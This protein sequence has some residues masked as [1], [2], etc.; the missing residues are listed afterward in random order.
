MGAP[1]PAAA[2]RSRNG[3]RA[4]RAAG[5]VALGAL[6]GCAGEQSALAPAGRDAERIAELFWWMGGGAVVIW[7][8]MVALSIY[9]IRGGAARDKER[10][11]R[12]LIVGGGAVFPTVTLLVLLVFGLSA[13][14]ELLALPAEG[15][16]RV[17]V[18]GE[19]WW[20]RVRYRLDDGRVAELANEVRLARGER[21][22]FVLES[23]DVIHSFWVPA[24]G[25]KVDMIPG[26]TTQLALEPTR[27][28]TY[29][30]TCAEYCGSAHA[31]MSFYAVVSERHELE[32]WL[33]QQAE[34]AREPRGELAREGAR[35]F[36]ATGCGACHTV[37]GTAAD[38][39]V[40]PDL[41]HVASRVSL[42]GGILPNDERAFLRWLVSAQALKPGVH[43]PAFDMLPE[44]ELRALA[45]YLE[46]LE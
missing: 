20:W 43:M 18:V 4:R 28:G 5:F 31:Q 39:R 29:R 15:A 17:E 36:L 34:P 11:A 14:P 24:L 37:R 22:L 33:E 19:Q 40:G 44:D 26:R 2:G 23:A 32:R 25:G 46:S 41:T 42:G 27:N 45:A 9:A 7:A 38:G 10:A 3:L 12:W 35:V 8:A 13:M 1:P 6:A 16:T 21:T 30:G